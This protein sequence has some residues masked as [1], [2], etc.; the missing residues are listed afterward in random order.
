MKLL[1]KLRAD[2]WMVAAHND[3]RLNGELFTFWLLTKG[4]RF[5][6]GEGRTDEE[7]LLRA[8]DAAAGR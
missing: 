8:L 2:G 1:H 4:D 7:A 6:K 3:Y 5:I